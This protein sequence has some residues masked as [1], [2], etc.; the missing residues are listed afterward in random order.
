V[1]EKREGEMV[2]V[3]H[4]REWF[5]TPFLIPGVVAESLRSD[6][7]LIP[8]GIALLPRMRLTSIHA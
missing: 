1:R 5:L 8:E 6:I 7:Q 4:R 2:P 3:R